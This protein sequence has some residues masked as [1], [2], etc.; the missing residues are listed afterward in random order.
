MTQETFGPAVGIASCASLD[1]AVEHAN[2]VP[3]G[4]AA[5]LYTENLGEAMRFAARLDFGNVG[6]NT[7]DA[8]II[9]APYGGRRESGFGYEHGKEGLEGYLQ[10]KHI[11]IRHSH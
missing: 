6:V 2:R 9:N 3:G 11:R 10:L 5:Y 8:G 4:L 1:E 7:T